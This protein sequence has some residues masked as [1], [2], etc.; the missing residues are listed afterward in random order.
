[1]PREYSICHKKVKT[2]QRGSRF[3]R[4]T[5]HDLRWG[6]QKLWKA[7]S[8]HTSKSA[9]LPAACYVCVGVDP[10][11]RLARCGWWLHHNWSCARAAALRSEVEKHFCRSGEND[12]HQSVN[13][14]RRAPWRRGCA[15][16]PIETQISQL[17]VVQ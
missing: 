9:P 7:C 2:L 16:R 1:M 11:A 8:I 12:V 15:E 17:L 14:W 6:K 13:P 3:L 10:A 4:G 5:K